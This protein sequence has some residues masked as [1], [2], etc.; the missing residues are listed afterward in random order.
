MIIPCLVKGSN[1]K[2]AEV[3]VSKS[4]GDKFQR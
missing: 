4:A 2:N 3:T 1:H